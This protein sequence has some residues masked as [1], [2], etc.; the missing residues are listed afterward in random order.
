M[1]LDTLF[2][3]EKKPFKKIALLFTI[4]CAILPVM[5]A[6][7]GLLSTPFAPLFFEHDYL[8]FGAIYTLYFYGLFLSWQ[9]HK[10]WVPFILLLVHLLF[11]LA[12]IFGEQTNWLVYLSIVTIMT[13][14]L[15]NQYFRMGSTAC[16]NDCGLLDD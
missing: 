13:T 7:A 3:S 16:S 11:V 15:S 14:S 8:L 2:Y 5:L 6:T 12:F 1:I 9:M 4:P 10:K